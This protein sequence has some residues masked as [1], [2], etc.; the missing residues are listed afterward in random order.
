MKNKI[1]GI[2]NMITKKNIENNIGIIGLGVIV[3]I[4]IV[5][6][7]IYLIGTKNISGIEKKELMRVSDELI[8]YI[9]DLYMH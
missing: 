9:E 5:F 7:A 1:Q 2:K 6:T 3:L 4:F 8:P